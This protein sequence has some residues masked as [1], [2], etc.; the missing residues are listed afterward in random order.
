MLSTPQP[1]RFALVY[2]GFGATEG[3]LALLSRQL[4]DDLQAKGFQVISVEVPDQGHVWPLWRR[5]VG[6]VLQLLFQP[7]SQR[8]LGSH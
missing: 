4:A 5:M 7:L 1:T 6:D 3:S 2:L 8:R